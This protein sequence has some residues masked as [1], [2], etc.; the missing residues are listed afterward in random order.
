MIRLVFYFFIAVS[1]GQQFMQLSN[2]N[3]DITPMPR[4]NMAIASDP[5]DIN[6]F[7]LFGG[8]YLNIVNENNTFYGDL[9]R[10][11]LDFSKSTTYTWEEVVPL[12]AS[13]IPSPRSFACLN[14]IQLRYY[15]SPPL[16]AL[17]GGSTFNITTGTNIPVSD[18]FY[19]YNV[20]T[21]VW[22]NLTTDASGDGLT[23]R[24]GCACAGFLNKLYVYGGVNSSGS[25]LNELWVYDL[26]NNVFTNKASPSASARWLANAA[27]ISIY[28]SAAII[29]HGGVTK[30]PLI[31][32]NNLNITQSDILDDTL[33]YD[34]IAENWT[35]ISTTDNV[36]P[37]RIRSAFA[38]NPVTNEIIQFGGDVVNSTFLNT[39]LPQFNPFLHNI[40]YTDCA[41]GQVGY[42]VGQIWTYKNEIKFWKNITVYASGANLNTNFVP[43]VANAGMTLL[44][45][46]LYIIGGIMVQ[47]PLV[48]VINNINVT[49]VCAQGFG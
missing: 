9:W 19:I 32:N 5:L 45:S 7:Y 29:F 4:S 35:V 12:I 31:I 28:R 47:C 14:T 1:Y 15:S 30:Y 33:E 17:F 23:P 25:V 37:K 46:C 18:H 36:F 6:A 2:N 44:G 40:S 11:S 8:N 41:V 34:I 43:P 3:V 13:D 48:N 21:G 27:S 39:S 24:T 26:S 16:L 22:S 42:T 49:R 10:F 20:F 38:S